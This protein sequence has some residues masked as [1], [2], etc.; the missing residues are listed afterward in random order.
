MQASEALRVPR[1]RVICIM[2][3]GING[4]PLA[5]IAVNINGMLFVL[6]YRLAA[7]LKFS[8]VGN[9]LIIVEILQIPFR[10]LAVA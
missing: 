5:E 2:V 1:R 3:I 8:D 10:R 4:I 9:E 6:S 7:S